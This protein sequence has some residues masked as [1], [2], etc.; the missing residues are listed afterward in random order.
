[1]LMTH[2]PGM[3]VSEK[4]GWE[5]IDHSHYSA[6]W[7]FKSVVMPMSL[8]PRRFTAM[9]NWFIPVPFSRCPCQR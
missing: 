7:F 6:R 2:F 4:T 5:E 8:L 3:L 1:M 9:L